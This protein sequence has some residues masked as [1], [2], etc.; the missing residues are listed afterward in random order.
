M[1]YA[2]R[3][4]FI[5][6]LISSLLFAAG[7]FAQSADDLSQAAEQARATGMPI[8]VVF[9]AEEC[10]YCERMKKE[11]LIPQLQQGE[12]QKKVLVREVDIQAAGK[13]GDFDGLRIRNGNFVHRYEVFATPTVVLVD[14][15]G[16]VLTTP[17]VGY[18][19]VQDYAQRLEQA[20]NTAK[21]SLRTTAS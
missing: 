10:P 14:P 15:E 11:F 1:S 5:A 20:I 8:M 12:L 21:H 3:W 19:D 7:V 13:I 2:K 4:S 6:L 9:G 17:L 18:S 16:K